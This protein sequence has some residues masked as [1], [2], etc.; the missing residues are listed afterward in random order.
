MKFELFAT[1]LAS[2]S[3]FEFYSYTS[4]FFFS[5]HLVT[6][7]IQV[8]GFPAISPPINIWLTSSF[9]SSYFWDFRDFLVP[10]LLFPFILTLAN[11]YSFAKLCPTLC[12]PMGCSPPGCSVH[13]IFQARI[14]EWGA[15]AF[16]VVF[17]VA[18]NPDSWTRLSGFKFLL[19]PLIGVWL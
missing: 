1:S 11:I 12:Y 8:I 14:L 10:P 17:L 9:C 7:E 13:I 5:L 3:P 6:L 19:H 15:I 2:F 16:S 18:Q 4:F